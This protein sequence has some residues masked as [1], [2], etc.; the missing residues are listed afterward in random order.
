MEGSWSKK[1]K[2]PMRAGRN[3]LQ[4]NSIGTL[5]LMIVFPA[6]SHNTQSETNLEYLQPWKRCAELLSRRRTTRHLESME[7]LQK[8][9]NG[10]RNSPHNYTLLFWKSGTMKKSQ[11][12]LEMLWLWWFSRKEINMTIEIIE[13]SVSNVRKGPWKTSPEPSSSCQWHSSWISMWVS[14]I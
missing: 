11:M 4:I 2:S 1:W 10:E 12:N 5:L 14:T 6:S 9:T 7:S 8:F 3:C 13:E